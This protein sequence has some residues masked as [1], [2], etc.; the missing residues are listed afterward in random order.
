MLSANTIKRQVKG[1]SNS[2]QLWGVMEYPVW[3]RPC[4]NGSPIIQVT[5]TLGSVTIVSPHF[6]A[7]ENLRTKGHTGSR[8]IGVQLCFDYRGQALFAKQLE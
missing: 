6:T 1:S 7:L 4:A 2:E 3:A 5:T 8:R